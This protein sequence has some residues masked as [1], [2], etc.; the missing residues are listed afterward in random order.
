MMAVPVHTIK[1]CGGVDIHIH[2]FSTFAL[3]GCQWQVLHPGRFTP[4]RESA[5]GIH[6]IGGWEVPRTDGNML[7]PKKYKVLSLLWTENV[8][9]CK[10]HSFASTNYAVLDPQD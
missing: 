8:L 2:S 9:H 10:A 1:A 7:H 5:H 4:H 3:N 6:L